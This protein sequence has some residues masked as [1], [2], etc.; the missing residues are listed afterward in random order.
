MKRALCLHKFPYIVC[1]MVL[2]LSVILRNVFE[3][4]FEKSGNCHWAEFASTIKHILLAML[5]E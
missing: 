4:H 1:R 5:D 3:I 2:T